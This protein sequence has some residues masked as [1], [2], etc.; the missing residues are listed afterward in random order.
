M[1][2]NDR[3]FDLSDAKKERVEQILKI[4]EAPTYHFLRFGIFRKKNGSCSNNY[5]H[6][7][8]IKLFKQSHYLKEENNFLETFFY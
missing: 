2:W 1:T 5:H 6:F 7:W 8:V 3:H 4:L